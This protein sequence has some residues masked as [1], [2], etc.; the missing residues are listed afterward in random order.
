VALLAPAAPTWRAQ[1]LLN[2]IRQKPLEERLHVRT[3]EG[4]ELAPDASSCASVIFDMAVAPFV[5]TLGPWCSLT[6]KVLSPSAY[7][8]A[9][10]ATLLN[11]R[12]WRLSN[13][14]CSSTST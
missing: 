5:Q 2:L 14:S 7:F 1:Q 9:F 4:L 8:H 11:R 13:W 6:R 12:R 3:F 10:K